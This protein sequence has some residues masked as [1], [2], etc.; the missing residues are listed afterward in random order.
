M[1]TRGPLKVNLRVIVL[2]RPHF[3]L[4]HRVFFFFLEQN[5]KGKGIFNFEDKPGYSTRN[6]TEIFN[7]EKMAFRPFSD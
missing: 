1:Q 3:F 5:S 2:S 7:N 4:L 6:N